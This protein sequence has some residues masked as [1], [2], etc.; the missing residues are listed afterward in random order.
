VAERAP[1]QALFG[2]SALLF[3]ASVAVTIVW[4]APMSAMVEMP[5]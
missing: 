2:V 3:G 4:C 5:V 1:Q